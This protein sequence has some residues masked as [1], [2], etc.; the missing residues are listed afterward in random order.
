MAEHSE[1]SSGVEHVV[2]ISTYVGVFLALIALTALTT[3]VAYIDLGQW[4]T[5]AA[6]LIAVVKM[7]LVVLFFM[8]VKYAAGL[9]RI[10][11]LAG[12]FWLAIMITLTLSDELTRGWEIVSHGWGVIVPLVLRLF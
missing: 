4:N 10:A 6:L 11:I 1:H 3:G 9:T 12:F 5:V 8:H 7:L 2:P